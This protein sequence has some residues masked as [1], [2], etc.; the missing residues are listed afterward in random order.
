MSKTDCYVRAFGICSSFDHSNLVDDRHFPKTT[1]VNPDQ[2]AKYLTF[3]TTM[4]VAVTQAS[5]YSHRGETNWPIFRRSLVNNTN[6]MTANESCIL[7]ITWLS[8]RSLAVPLVP[9]N[10]AVTT[11]GTI[12]ISRVIKRRSQG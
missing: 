10:A 3:R 1:P 9:K 11:A 4:I 2:S 6:G 5:A 7:R 12:A 8:R